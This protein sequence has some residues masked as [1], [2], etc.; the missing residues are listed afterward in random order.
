V[1]FTLRRDGPGGAVRAEVAGH[2]RPPDAAA[3]LGKDDSDAPME[4]PPLGRAY[5]TGDGG[6]DG[7]AA[8]G[9]AAAG[10]RECAAEEDEA[11]DDAG[12][13]ACKRTLSWSE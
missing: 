2:V 3:P 12:P 13:G 5:A 8:A 11:S 7:A 10:G 9:D 4:A 6:A 1:V